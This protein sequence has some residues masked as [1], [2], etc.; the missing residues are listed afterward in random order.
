ME[1]IRT[2]EAMQRR[3][4][5]L[6]ASGSTLSLVPTMGFFHEGHLELMRVG[7]RRSQKLII[8]IYVNPTQFGPGED[9]ERYPRDEKGDLAKADAVG[10][11]SMFDTKW[12]RRCAFQ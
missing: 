3:S 12:G 1:I 9:F 8:S 11:P 7:K 4:E 10:V 2:V 5:E 6:R